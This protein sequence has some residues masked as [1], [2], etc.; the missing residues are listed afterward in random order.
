MPTTRKERSTLA[1]EMAMV[2]GIIKRGFDITQ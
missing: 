1:A 2:A